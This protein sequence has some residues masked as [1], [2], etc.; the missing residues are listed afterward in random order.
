MYQPKPF[1]GGDVQALAAYLDAELRAISQAATD[2]VSL[3][4]LDVL[5]AAPRKPSEGMVVC[6]SGSPDW[7]P[8]GA[9]GG[10]FGYFSGAWVKLNN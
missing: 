5:H 7:E 1:L 8:L 10:F 4:K 9:G 3:L 6:A 2:T